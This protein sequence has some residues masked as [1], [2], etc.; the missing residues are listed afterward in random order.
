M[1]AGKK[2]RP[3]RVHTD[4]SLQ[5]ERDKTDREIE[6][7]VPQTEARADR[8]LA[9]A[10]DRA[11]ATLDVARERADATLEATHAAPAAVAAITEN[12]AREDAILEEE[13]KAAAGTLDD[14][15]TARKEALA[16]LLRIER[17]ETDD[18][19][20][21]ERDRADDVVASRDN[22]LAM[23]SHDLR[24]LLGGVA[25][26][27]ASVLQHS[28]DERSRED[29]KRIQRCTVRMTR[30]VGD[31]IDVV[32]M[33]AGKLSLAPAR[34]DARALVLDVVETFRPDADS[35][36]ISIEAS[37][38]DGDVTSTFDAQRIQQ[39]L[40]NL[41]GNALKFTG[42]G[43]SVDV[44]LA[45]DGNELHFAVLDTG[46]GIARDSA[47]RIFDRFWQSTVGDRRGLGLGLYISRSIVEG[48][49]GKIWVDERA[50]GGSVF[51]FRLPVV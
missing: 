2:R 15:R 42:E 19:L 34:Q 41:I 7:G 1:A 36:G 20:L 8:V 5:R 13:R 50:E 22:F 18:R 23:V 30:L 43:G 51:H 44:T 37:V 39:V 38:I 17:A 24:N 32:S 16:A 12:R 21:L 33:E 40:A 6:K 29:A 14:E 25:L 4:E 28:P 47:A 46:P 3:E 26:G 27:A 9:R 35:K 48:H 31:L 11:A 45:R 10:R 49:G